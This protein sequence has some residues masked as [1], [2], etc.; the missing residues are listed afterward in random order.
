[1]Y[2]FWPHRFIGRRIACIFGKIFAVTSYWQNRTLFYSLTRYFVDPSLY[3]GW[4]RPSPTERCPDG[5]T[6]IGCSSSEIRTKV[7][8]FAKRCAY[9]YKMWAI[10]HQ[11]IALLL[12]NYAS[13]FQRE[14]SFLSCKLLACPWTLYQAVFWT[15]WEILETTLPCDTY[16]S[17]L[18]D[19][20]HCT[21]LLLPLVSS[22]GSVHWPM[23]ALS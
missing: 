18:R 3:Y 10:H 13:R 5:N 16:I 22:I 19:V 17:L 11:S 23:F 1:M 14:I 15:I 2:M 8:R 6:S 21:P 4:L 12:N 7:R 9:R 20:G